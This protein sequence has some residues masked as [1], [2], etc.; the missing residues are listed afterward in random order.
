MWYLRK[1]PLILIPE[2]ETF[3]MVIC[4]LEFSALFNAPILQY[5]NTPKGLAIFTGKAIEP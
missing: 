4:H 2:T 5:P 1:I 3:V